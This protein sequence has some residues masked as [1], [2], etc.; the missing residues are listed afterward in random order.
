M[1]CPNCQ[2]PCSDRDRYC[3]FCGAAIPNF[4]PRKGRHWVPVLILV[5][6]TALGIGLFFALPVGV[7]SGETPWFRT[8]DGVLYFDAARYSGSNLQIPETINGETVTAL[9]DGCFENCT[10]LT[11]VTLPETL[12]AIGADAF[13]GCTGLRGIDIPESVLFIGESAFS[14]CTALEAARLSDNIRS[15]G[16]GAFADCHKLHFVYFQGVF[17][18]WQELY[19]E[20]ISPLTVVFAD[21]GSFPQGG[22]AY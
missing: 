19:N 12:Q 21:D 8:E 18:D 1:L 9:A 20:F 7:P 15:I 16:P 5:I 4:S 6:L 11:S 14:G 2:Q 3:A 10:E 13:R 22:N 17:A